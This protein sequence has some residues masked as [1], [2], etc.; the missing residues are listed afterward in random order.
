MLV[1]DT[2]YVLMGL[3]QREAQC[4]TLFWSM[5]CPGTFMRGFL[6]ADYKQWNY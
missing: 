3:N 1:G 6:A 4:L 5:R 2:F